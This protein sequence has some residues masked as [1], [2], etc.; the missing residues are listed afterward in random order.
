MMLGIES[1]RHLY[2]LFDPMAICITLIVIDNVFLVN[3]YVQNH[4]VVY[5]K[6]CRF[7]FLIADS[8]IVGLGI[9]SILEA[10]AKDCVH[11]LILIMG[12]SLPFHI[13]VSVGFL[14]TSSSS[15]CLLLGLYSRILLVGMGTIWKCWVSNPRLVAYKASGLPIIP[16]L[17]PTLVAF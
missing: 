2:D 8:H 14:V 17:W 1:N 13:F 7:Y 11:A 9:S 12:V 3:I 4:Q 16:S 10:H 5:M 15:Q 6:Y